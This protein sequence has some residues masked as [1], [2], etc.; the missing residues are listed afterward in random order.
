MSKK[1]ILGIVGVVVA[2]LFIAAAS[3]RTIPYSQNRAVESYVGTYANSGIDT[4]ILTRDPG[5]Q[6]ISFGAQFGDSVATFATS[7]AVVRRVINGV[8]T[9]AIGSDTLS[10]WSAYTSTT[11]GNTSSGV[12]ANGTALVGKIALEPLA[13][14]YLVILK[15][16]AAG[17]GT[18][19]PNVKYEHLKA[20]GTH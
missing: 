18:T 8:L 2:M 5:E 12:F 14:Q 7:A 3:Q 19:T 6:Y 15:Y 16:A 10:G 20:F 4:V 9:P 13:D 17:N 1:L 11:D